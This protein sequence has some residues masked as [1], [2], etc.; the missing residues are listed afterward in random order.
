M[1]PI[2]EED[3]VANCGFSASFTQAFSPSCTHYFHYHAP[4]IFTIMHPSFS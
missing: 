4:T 3:F 2:V 1:R